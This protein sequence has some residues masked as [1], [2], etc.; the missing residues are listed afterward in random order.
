M[1]RLIR[2]EALRLTTTRTYWLLAAG[3]IALIAGGSPPPPRPPAS[4]LAPAR[5]VPTAASCISAPGVRTPARR[6]PMPLP[7]IWAVTST[8]PGKTGSMTRWTPARRPG[9]PCTGGRATTGS[10]P[11]LR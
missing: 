2:A 1:I 9:S 6:W 7:A 10:R 5:P 4:P 11:I 3:A 8:S